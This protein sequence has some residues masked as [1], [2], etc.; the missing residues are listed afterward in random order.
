MLLHGLG[1]SGDDLAPV[2]P[3]LGRDD[4]LFVLPTAPTRRV[5]INGGYPMPA[6]YDI[7]SMDRADPNREVEEDIREAAEDIAALMVYE[8]PKRWILAGFSQGGAI[9]LHLGW[10]HPEPLVGVLAM[11]TYLVLEHTL[12][13]ERNP[14]NEGTPALFCHGAHDDVVPMVRGQRAFDRWNVARSCRLESYPMAHELCLPEVRHIA[15]WLN[16]VAPVG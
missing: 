4:L 11:S 1:A 3:H 7:T 15:A 10:R 9:A 5:T 16:E 13:A 2:V 6:W 8:G 12:D 14:A